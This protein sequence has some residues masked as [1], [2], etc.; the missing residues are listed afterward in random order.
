MARRD[1]ISSEI[2]Y[3]AMLMGS[4]DYAKAI[5]DFAVKRRQ[6]HAAAGTP[7]DNDSCK[8]G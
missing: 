4:E 7:A 5:E 1:R 2:T 6:R 3:Q 8:S